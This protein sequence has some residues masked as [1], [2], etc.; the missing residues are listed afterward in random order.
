[1][2]SP[3]KNYLSISM[4][5]VLASVC[6]YIL[7]FYFYQDT[8]G[9]GIP[10]GRSYLGFNLRDGS[11][12]CWLAT[13]F[14]S[15][16]LSI[17]L[18]TQKRIGLWGFIVL[19]VWMTFAHYCAVS[20]AVQMYEA[21]YDHSDPTQT[22]E[23][24]LLAGL[25]GSGLSFLLIATIGRKV[26]SGTNLTILLAATMALGFLGYFGIEVPWI[27]ED[28]FNSSF[29]F[30]RFALPINLNLPWQLVFGATII[31]VLRDHRVTQ[32]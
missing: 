24:G 8:S 29:R 23:P 20:V 32:N 12:V 14:F 21:E 19:T 9:D 2:D 25:V 22:W 3:N 16:P 15:L 5:V 11:D 26:R 4:I 31:W 18:F 17:W 13:P 28:K 7:S 30:A 6:C 1:M 10:S 27:G